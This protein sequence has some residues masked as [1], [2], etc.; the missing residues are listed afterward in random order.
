[1]WSYVLSVA[2]VLL[3][4]ET[5]IDKGTALCHASPHA[6][7]ASQRVSRSNAVLRSGKL[8]CGQQESG[9]SRVRECEKQIPGTRQRPGFDAADRIG[10]ITNV[11][12]QPGCRCCSCIA[13]SRTHR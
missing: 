8:W 9:S 12:Q 6:R 3:A 11:R 7:T 1:M 13:G 5:A 10:A 4:L 2:A